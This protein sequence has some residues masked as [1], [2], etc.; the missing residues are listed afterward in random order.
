MEKLIIKSIGYYLNSLAMISPS[1]TGKKGYQ[2]MCTPIRKPLKPHHKAYLREGAMEVLN[3][4]GIPIQTY[5]WGSGDHTILLLH[6]WQSHTFRWRHYIDA[7]VKEGYRV[8]ALDAPAHGLSGGKMV[9]ALI[10]GETIKTFLEKYGPVNSIVSHSFGGFA[11]MYA[12]FNY[13]H[14]RTDSIVLMGVPGDAGDF[15]SEVQRKLDLKDRTV[16]M[17]KTH[18]EK[19]FGLP[20]EYYNLKRFSTKINTPGLIIHDVEDSDA[21]YHHALSLSKNWNGSKLITT[22][23]EGHKLI[24]DDLIQKTSEF[25]RE[26]V[27]VQHRKV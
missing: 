23:G 21:P 20:I 22:T 24:S 4:N 10:Y 18:F 11:S 13:E 1:A 8:T 12:L 7:L 25:I 27:N 17:V 5:A 2:L 15:I 16:D 14:L 3:V 9:N 19:A 26:V 6:G